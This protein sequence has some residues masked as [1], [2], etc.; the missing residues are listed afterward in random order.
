[1]ERDSNMHGCRALPIADANG[2]RTQ[3]RIVAMALT[4]VTLISVMIASGTGA[5]LAEGV[6]VTPETYIRA[7]TDV[8]FAD[9]QRRAGGMINTNAFVRQPTLLSDQPV[10]R[11]N[12]DTLYGSAVVDTEGGATIT[13]P[14]AAD[15]R[16][17]SVLVID[18]DHY[19]PAVYYA[20][21]TYDL[22]DETR[23]VALLYRVQLLD[24]SDPADVAAANALQDQFVVT[25]SSAVA[26]PA[27][28]WD[29]DSMLALR[30]AYEAE[31]RKFAQFEPDWMGPRGEVNEETRHLAAAG[32][33]GLFPE[34]DAVYINYAGPPDAGACYTATYETPETDAFWSITVYGADGFMKSDANVINDRNVTPNGDGTFTAFFGSE[35]ACGARPN[36]VDISEGWNFLMRIYR[37]G[38]EVL[39][40]EYTLPEVSVVQ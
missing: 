16:Y 36:R 19:A 22:P 7:E 10:I 14:E 6:V 40:R 23:Y 33:W 39:S 17:L 11:M 18:N 15:G 8:A 24:Y 1:M 5:A 29:V 26:F 13:V 4:R 21:G 31:F 27:P 34:K 25:A 2:R 37:P 3:E 28:Q 20:P 38:P 12:R 35:D 30:T 32:A 9:F